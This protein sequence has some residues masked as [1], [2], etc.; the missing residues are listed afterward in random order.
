MFSISPRSLCL[1]LLLCHPACHLFM[2]TGP[3]VLN[4]QLRQANK[5]SL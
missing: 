3:T 5:Q 4:R 2:T 1:T